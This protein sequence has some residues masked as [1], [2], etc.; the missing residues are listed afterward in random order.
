MQQNDYCMQVECDDSYGS[1][2]LC[3][4]RADDVA[5]VVGKNLVVMRVMKMTVLRY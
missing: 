1:L 3:Q 2:Q 5:D 4:M